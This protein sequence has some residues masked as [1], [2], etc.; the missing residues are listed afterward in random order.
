D[1][2]FAL[3]FRRACE[4]ISSGIGKPGF[5]AV[6]SRISKGLSRQK[7]ICRSKPNIGPLQDNACLFGY[8]KSFRIRG[9]DLSGQN[10]YIFRSQLS[11]FR[12][13]GWRIGPKIR[14]G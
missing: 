10:G 3:P 4:A 2:T 8:L 1:N 9:N 12:N 13:M 14:Y 7:L 11:V 6:I 5:E